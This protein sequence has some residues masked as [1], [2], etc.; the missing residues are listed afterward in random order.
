MAEAIVWLYLAQLLEEE[1]HRRPLRKP[2]PLA[3]GGGMAQG[4]DKRLTRAVK[5]GGTVHDEASETRTQRTCFRPGKRL[6]VVQEHWERSRRM[7]AQCPG[8]D[9]TGDRR[10]AAECPGMD[11]TGDRRMAA[12]CPGMDSTGDRRMAAECPGMDSTGDRRMAAECPG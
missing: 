8:M 12:E 1:W 3:A 11:P 10:M 2:Y 6:Q 4:R 7:A 5:R 9:P